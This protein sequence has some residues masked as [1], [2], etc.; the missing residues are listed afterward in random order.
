MTPLHTVT[1]EVMSTI[2]AIV[3][4]AMWIPLQLKMYFAGGGLA[5]RERHGC[6]CPI[7]EVPFQKISAVALKTLRN[8]RLPCRRNS[9][10]TTATY[11]PT[12]TVNDA[13]GTVARRSFKARTNTSA[14]A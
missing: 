1:S 5:F 7:S 12:F 4:L 13:A 10:I 14:M 11:A 6:R 3:S 9:A 2:A 8:A